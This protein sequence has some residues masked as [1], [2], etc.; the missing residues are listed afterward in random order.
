VKERERIENCRR[1]W[2]LLDLTEPT[3]IE[4]LLQDEKGRYHMSSWPNFYIGIDNIG[5]TIGL[6]EHIS[7]TR[8]KPGT[9]LS[10][11][12]YEGHED[13]SR[14]LTMT[15]ALKISKKTKDNDLYCA[16]D[17]VYYAKLN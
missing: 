12:E 14:V 7:E 8:F 3:T 9:I 15:P 2:V 16:V 17:K 1:S 5:D 10:F 6:V 11:S 4:L 13:L